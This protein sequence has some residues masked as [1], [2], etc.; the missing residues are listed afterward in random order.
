MCLFA[1]PV[2]I[3]GELLSI[4]Q[5]LDIS[6]IQL[7]GVCVVFMYCVFAGERFVWN[8]KIKRCSKFIFQPFPWRATCKLGQLQATTHHPLDQSHTNIYN[9]IR[10]NMCTHYLFYNNAMNF[11]I[12]TCMCQNMVKDDVCIS[13]AKTVHLFCVSAFARE[14]PSGCSEVIEHCP[15]HFLTH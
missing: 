13:S 4:F 15:S 2:G 3:C 10:Q 14:V 11:V 12:I 5:L 7:C 9:I 6:I 8:V 1:A